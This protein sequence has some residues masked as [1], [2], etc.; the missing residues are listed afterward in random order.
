MAKKTLEIPDLGGVERAEVVEILVSVGQELSLE[1]PI[2]V[3]ESDKASMEV[4]TEVTG[5]VLAVH[6]KLGE[7]VQEGAA[8]LDIEVSQQSEGADK[9][10]MTKTAIA[11]EKLAVVQSSATEK[12]SSQDLI[13]STAVPN[14]SMAIE[15]SVKHLE[16]TRLGVYAGPSVR[17]IAHALGLD[18]SIIAA[19]TSKR[20]HVSRADLYAYLKA[21]IGPG[22][23]SVA[24]SP[25]E[26]P[27]RFGPVQRQKLS[28]IKQ[29]TVRHMQRC[30]E[31]PQ[32]TQFELV[33]IS[34][35][36]QLR[37]QYKAPLAQQGIRLTVLAFVIKA[38]A[39]VLPRH[40]E[41]NA[42]LDQDMKTLLI[43]Q[44]YRVGVA[45][46]SAKGLVVPVL[47]DIDQLDVG[48]IAKRLQEVSAQVRAKGCLPEM[49]QGGTFTVSSL[50][51]IGGVGFTPIVNAPQVAIL[52]VSRASMQ[53]VWSE[54]AKEFQPR[55]MLPLALSYDH[56]V[57]DGAQALR[58]LVDFAKELTGIDTV[59][60]MGDIDAKK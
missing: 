24:N 49:L 14:D 28:K 9:N 42:S 40:P 6:I 10:T 27:E 2:C 45:V 21:Q 37:Q 59:T 31:I 52:G 8:L 33:D 54:E 13:Q 29:A 1:Q 22:Q 38:L 25:D 57:I 17:R 39:S 12:S 3:L 50:G 16:R 56:R 48:S 34:A 46:D 20:A 19:E 5:T 43:K 32:V 23:S 60:M 47:A 58:F 35:L 44:Y 36:E 55:L 4:P 53:P 26:D 41:L 18:L 15:E 11:A 7:Q 30:L 51:G